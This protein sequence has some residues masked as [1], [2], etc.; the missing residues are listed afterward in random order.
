MKLEEIKRAVK[1]GKKV[2]WKHLDYQVKVDK[3]DNWTINHAGGHI[4]GLVHNDETT[5][6]GKEEDFHTIH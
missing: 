6:N 3:N 1:N 4:I 5:L 2:Y